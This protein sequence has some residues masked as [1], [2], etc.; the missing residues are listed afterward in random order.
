MCTLEVSKMGTGGG[1]GGIEIYKIK[2][3]VWGGK[4]V[5]TMQ[6]LFSCYSDHVAIFITFLDKMCSVIGI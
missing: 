1:I 5:N 6:T 4:L 3:E 2:L